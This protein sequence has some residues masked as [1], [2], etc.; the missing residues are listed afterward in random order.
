M[1][2]RIS[3]TSRSM[4]STP[5]RSLASNIEDHI[6]ERGGAD[7]ASYFNRKDKE[8]ALRLLKKLEENVKEDVDLD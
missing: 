7:E 3:L 1:L 2:A 5:V 6:K 4:L 8:A